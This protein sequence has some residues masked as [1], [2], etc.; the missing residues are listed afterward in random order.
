VLT[1]IAGFYLLL[2][3]SVATPAAAQK[4]WPVSLDSLAVGHV[5][6]THV[7]VRGTV[8]YA[9]WQDDGDLHIKLVT[10]FGSGRFIIAEC[11]PK[12]PCVKPATGADVIV[13]GIT[14]RDPEH[15]WWEIHP[16]L[17]IQAAT[18]GE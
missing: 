14:R 2:A 5:P 11:I 7:E 13:R 15:G 18:Q 1:R 12:L 17:F 4:F 8:V 10:P 6:H 16:V 9:R 3:A